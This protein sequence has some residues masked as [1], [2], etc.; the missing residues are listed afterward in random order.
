MLERPQPLFLPQSERLSFA[1]MQTI[2]RV[3]G[4]QRDHPL[5]EVCTKSLYSLDSV[6][7]CP[8]SVG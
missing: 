8:L 3:V 5:A 1:P 7:L 6:A 4:S 2:V